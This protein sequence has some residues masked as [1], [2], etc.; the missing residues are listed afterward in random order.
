MSVPSES[1]RRLQRQAAAHASWANTPNR[2][3]RLAP[4][5][6]A[7]DA[8]FD[9]LV[10]PDGVMN[11]ADRAKAAASARKAFY[12][13]MARKSAAARRRRTEAQAL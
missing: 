13:E 4:A 1:E 11:P 12:T 2:A 6:A 8:R 10:D 3:A 5:H 7:R 9:K